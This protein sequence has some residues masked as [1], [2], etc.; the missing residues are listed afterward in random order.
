M[1]TALKTITRLILPASIVAYLKPFLRKSVSILYIGSNYQCN[2]CLFKMRQ[3]VT[4]ETRDKLCPRCGS[5]P[6]TRGLWQLIQD[7]LA[8]KA[9]LHFSPPKSLRNRIAKH[10]HV[11]S[12]NTSDYLGEFSADKQ[13]DICA[14]DASDN[15]YDVIICFHVLEHV[16]DDVLAMSELYRVLCNGG[17][18][19]IQT[20]FQSGDIYEDDTII[21]AEDR[22][23]HFGQEDHLRIYSPEG[24]TKR[25]E[26]V[27]FMVEP[28]EL[29]NE[30]NNYYG[31]K[32]NETILVAKKA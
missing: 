11:A 5:L 12:Y 28:I 25:L 17:S 13:Y 7:N 16:S 3:F 14:I 4:L 6:R 27:G 20:P 22:K 23:K 26:H 31:L 30:E 10:I 21:S 2:I 15:S 24:L 1:Y 18:A 9:V 29:S 32:R 8:S 19:Y